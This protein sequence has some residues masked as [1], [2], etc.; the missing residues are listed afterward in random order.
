[1]NIKVGQKRKPLLK[2]LGGVTQFNAGGLAPEDIGRNHQVAI[3]G[4]LVGDGPNMFVYSK[5]FLHEQ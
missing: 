5:Y 3:G 4:V 1:M 2:A